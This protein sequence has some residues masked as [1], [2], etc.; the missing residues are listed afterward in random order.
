MLG[1]RNKKN[2]FQNTFL[3]ES[4]VLAALSMESHLDNETVLM[5]T[6]NIFCIRKEIILLTLK[7]PS[8]NVPENVVC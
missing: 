2:N 3:H 6:Q 7:A 1:L 4:Q 5:N 8:K